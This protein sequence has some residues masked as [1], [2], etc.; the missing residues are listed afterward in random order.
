MNKK[1][2]LYLLGALLLVLAVACADPA[3]DAPQAEVSA[4]A[5]EETPA[6]EPAAAMTYDELSADSKIGFVGSKVTGSHEGGFNTFTGS[7]AVA[8]DSPAGSSVEV[9]ID[10]TSLWADDDR[11]TGHLKSADFFD[12]ENYPTATFQSS[13]I[14]AN[15]DGTY[16]VTGNLDLHGVT[17]QISFPASIELTEGG[18][19][20]TAE[21]AIKRFD[22]GI[23]YPGKADDLIRDDVLIKLDLRSAMAGVEGEADGEGG[24]AEA[25]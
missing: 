8:G 17:K 13:Q 10:A 2:P 7:V 23:E 1:L 18:F 5:P 21:F 4:P 6:E 9:E 15:D 20:A 3:A 14:A 24:E 25:T 22:F 11:L 19:V 16:T 12:V